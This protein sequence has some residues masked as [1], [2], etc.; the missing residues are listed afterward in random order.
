[1]P[2]YEKFL[3]ELYTNKR[4][5]KKGEQVILSEE[6]SAILQWKL[7]PKLKDPGSFTVPCTIGK[8]SFDSAMLDLGASINLMPYH[9]YKTLGLDDINQDI[10]ISLRMA[11]RTL[12]FPRGVVEN[13]L[14]KV[15]ELYVLDDF[16]ILDMEESLD[17]EDEQPII[18]GRAFIA[19]A[20]TKLMCKKVSSQ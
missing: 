9:V 2:A 6:V 17:E 8:K 15:E 10:K 11:D 18:L 16:V 12:V 1:M 7:L 5:F 3:K 13:V 19:T 20:G 14:V 4:K